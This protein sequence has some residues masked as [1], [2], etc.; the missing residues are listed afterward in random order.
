M[1]RSS[2]VNKLQSIKHTSAQQGASFDTETT[3]TASQIDQRGK[4]AAM[5]R[6]SPL[7]LE[8]MLF[9]L[10]LYTRSSL[11][12]KF[13][14]MHELYQRVQSIPGALLE[15]G[16]WWGQNLILLENLRAIH[17]PFNK[18]RRII[19]FDT[20]SGYTQ[21]SEK[22][23]ESEVWIEHSYSTSKDYK[24]Y[25]TELLQVHEG[26]NVLGQLAGNHQLVEGDVEQTAPQYFRDH[27][28]TIVAMAY[29]DMGLYQPT[30]AA[31]TAIKPHLLSGSVILLDEL[32]WSES[33]GEALAFKEVFSRHEYL[34]EKCKLYPSKAI[35]TIK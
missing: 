31:L 4:L 12:V 33:P 29:F 24:A 13:I 7:P 8:D 30:K 21:P 17:E 18:Q 25:L 2:L 15:F 3:A 14:V 35:V 27:P 11:L 19:G 10:G 34:I 22:D 20:F 5:F 28:E 26:N 32:T 6:S 23:R 16:T 9:N 1:V